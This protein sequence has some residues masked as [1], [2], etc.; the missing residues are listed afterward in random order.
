MFQIVHLKSSKSFDVLRNAIRCTNPMSFFTDSVWEYCQKKP[1]AG[2][3]CFN[4]IVYEISSKFSR[5]RKPIPK[6]FLDEYRCFNSQLPPSQ[7]KIGKKCPSEPAS[8]RLQHVRLSAAA[9]SGCV[10]NCQAHRATGK[11]ARARSVRTVCGRHAMRRAVGSRR[12]AR[13]FFAGRNKV[14]V[15]HYLI[16]SGLCLQADDGVAKL[17]H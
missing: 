16:D 4:V 11:D 15:L 8:I 14:A 2:A 17:W 9:V 3:D 12:C 7:Q 1:A 10:P 6:I 5:I 13:L